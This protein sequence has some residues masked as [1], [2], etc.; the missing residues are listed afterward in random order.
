LPDAWR[1]SGSA[2]NHW[3]A[4]LMSRVSGAAF[5]VEPDTNQA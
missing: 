5:A 2:V 3:S 4:L 1:R